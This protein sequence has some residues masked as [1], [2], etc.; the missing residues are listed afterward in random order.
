MDGVIDG[1]KFLNSTFFRQKSASD[2][3]LLFLGDIVRHSPSCMFKIDL[4]FQK[5]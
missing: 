2:A 5:V 4:F 1:D 3:E